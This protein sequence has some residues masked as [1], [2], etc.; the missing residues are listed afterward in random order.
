MSPKYN[1]GGVAAWAPYKDKGKKKSQ[2]LHADGLREVTFLG[3]G[4]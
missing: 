2:G 3:E 4:R 1:K